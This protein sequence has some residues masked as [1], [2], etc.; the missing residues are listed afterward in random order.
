MKGK[1]DE[2]STLAISL[3]IQ[4]GD[5]K[6]LSPTYR[7]INYWIG[8]EWLQRGPDPE[9][10]GFNRNSLY[11]IRCYNVFGEDPDEQ[12]WYIG[13]PQKLTMREFQAIA[14]KKRRRDGSAAAELY[15]R[16][17]EDRMG[18]KRPTQTVAL[19][20]DIEL[21]TLQTVIKFI[22]SYGPTQIGEMGRT[23]ELI[24]AKKPFMWCDAKYIKDKPAW[25][26]VLAALLIPTFP[27]YSEFELQESYFYTSLDRLNLDNID[28]VFDLN[29]E[30][31]I[32]FLVQ[33]LQY[34]GWL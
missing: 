21:E 23:D 12:G 5:D 8:I 27:Y 6:E 7:P 29:G 14:K 3:N 32:S 30:Y 17:A 18:V 1:P 15:L 2:G 34:L 24:L 25:L 22:T 9:F 13:P 28:Q 11:Q 26:N 33:C 4:M 20:W 19:I 10:Y 31:L 16:D